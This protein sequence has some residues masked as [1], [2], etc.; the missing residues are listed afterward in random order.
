MQTNNQLLVFS[1]KSFK[2]DQIKIKTVQQIKSG[3]WEIKG[4]KYTKTFAQI[5]ARR[6]FHVQDISRNVLTKFTE[7]CMETPCWCPPGER[8]HGRR[9]P[10]KTSVTEFWHK[11]LNLFLKELINIK[12]ILFLIT[13][14]V[15]IA[16]FPEVRHSLNLEDS[17]L[18][19]DVN[20]MSRSSL[21]IQAYSITKPRTLLKRKFV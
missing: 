6:I 16:K 10:T 7:I 2:I 13:R 20:A 21:E 9:K 5:Q 3:I 14:I 12:V 1:V 11:S 8:Q 15:Q 18:S 19:C 17:S 4:G